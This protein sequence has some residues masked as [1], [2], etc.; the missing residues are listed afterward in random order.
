MEQ[1]R[2]NTAVAALMAYQNYLIKAQNLNISGDLWQKA[3]ETFTLLLSPF[4][5]FITEEVWQSIFD[6]QDSVHRQEWPIYDDELAAPE[7]ITII[8][9]VNGRVRDRLHVEAGI[10]QD[11]MAEAALASDS[12][13]RYVDGKQVKRI[14]TIPDE[15]VNIVV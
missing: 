2:F 13:R 6:Y 7:K 5:P 8:I 14:I 11:E 1:F 12:V 10:G 3:L 4:A 9:Q 15:L